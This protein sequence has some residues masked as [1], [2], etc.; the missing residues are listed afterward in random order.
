MITPLI[1]CTH[2]ATIPHSFLQTADR[3]RPLS[4]RLRL[5][6]TQ[7]LPTRIF[8]PAIFLTEKFADF[9]R[10][11]RNRKLTPCLWLVSACSAPL[12]AGGGTD[13]FQRAYSSG[14]S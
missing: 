5:A 13:L 11:S 12:P 6:W 10:L 8:I 9:W 2:Q 1:C 4:L 14:I 3:R 7:V